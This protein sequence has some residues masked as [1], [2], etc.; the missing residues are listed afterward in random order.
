MNEVELA[1]EALK[2]KIHAERGFNSHLYKDKC[3]QRRLA[4]RMRARGADDFRVYADLLDRDSVEYDRLIDTLTI[5]V[6]KFFRNFPTWEVLEREV[7]LISFGTMGR[8][9]G[10]GARGAPAGEEAYSLSILLREW[11]GARD[12][13]EDLARLS[14]TGRISTVKAWSPRESAAT[15]R[16]PLT[17]RR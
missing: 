13:V 12:R 10:S 5:N 9:C 14:I 4:L 8:R 7:S 3:L 6:T 1:L 16:S 2:F 11:A 15:P 17:K